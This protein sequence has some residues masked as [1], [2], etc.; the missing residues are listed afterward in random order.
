VRRKYRKD[1]RPTLPIEGATAFY[2]RYCADLIYKLHRHIR[3]AQLIWRYGS[4]LRRLRR[5][6]EARNYADAAMKLAGD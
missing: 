2:A 3:L 1:R 5:D 6:P 4:F